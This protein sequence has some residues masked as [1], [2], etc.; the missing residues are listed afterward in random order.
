[1]FVSRGY[2]SKN[3]KREEGNMADKVSMERPGFI[4]SVDSDQLGKASTK[5]EVDA[6]SD[7]LRNA[8]Q[9]YIGAWRKA[10]GD[11]EPKAGGA[12]NLVGL[13]LSGGGIRSATFSLGVIQALAH[14]GLLQKVDYLSTVS[15][16][17][18]IG[19]ALTWLVS[20]EAQRE[21]AA[22]ESKDTGAVNFGVARANFPFGADDPAP[23][24]ERQADDNQQRMLKYG[25]C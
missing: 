1:M 13:A 18:Y 20:G 25:V 24:A 4:D 9:K 8:E 23:D 7:R 6:S 19:S 5:G 17:G 15:G 21:Y 3:T 14:R 11:A 2:N 12:G 16:G 22:S 10:R